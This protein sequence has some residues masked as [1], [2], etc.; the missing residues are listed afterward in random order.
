MA[1]RRIMG[2][3][4]GRVMRRY[5]IVVPFVMAHLSLRRQPATNNQE[6]LSRAP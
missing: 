3:F 4:Q 6:A 2:Y 5:Y 1:E